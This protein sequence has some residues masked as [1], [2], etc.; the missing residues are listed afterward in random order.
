[1]SEKPTP[2]D[3]PSMAMALPEGVDFEEYV[4]ATY[5][6]EIS[7]NMG[8][9][10]K[11]AQA[12]AIEQSTGTWVCVPGETPEVRR[13]HVA[14]VLSVSQIPDYE[15]ERPGPKEE[16]YRTYILQIGFP[17][18]NVW[19][20]LGLLL[21]AIFGNI[22]MAGR[23]KMLDVRFP[24]KWLAEFKGPK[25]GIEGIRKLLKVPE[26]PLLNNMI[27]P[28]IYDSIKVGSELF[29]QAAVGGC[30]IIKDD[31]LLAN[32]AFNPISE[33][34]PAYMEMVDRAKSEKGEETLFTVNITDR[35]PNMLENA[36][37]AIE[38][39]AN[40]LMVNYP[41]VGLEIVRQICEDPSVKVPVLGHMDFAGAMYMAPQYGV[42]SHLIL[43]KFPRIAGCDILVHPAP[44]GKAS[45]L[46]DKFERVAHTCRMPLH[47]IKPMFPMPS[48]G[49]TVGMVDKCVESLG[50]DI[51]IGSGGGIHAHPD[52]AAA[53]AKAFRQAIDAVMQ[54]IKVKD[55]AKDHKELG[56]SLGTW[57]TGKIE[58]GKK[59]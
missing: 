43:A 6:G 23:L 54:G 18:E 12:I 38:L 56:V 3:Y 59:Y 8:I 57:G 32:Q 26:R 49:I 53:G 11:V 40:A 24:K 36:D 58:M 55:Y 42:S 48:G 51:V 27:K 52:G 50:P 39:G 35:M 22:S 2:D 25:F 33:R 28:C 19:N 46:N 21:T 29:Y 17:A 30:D 9:S 15:F 13:R 7:A 34:I 37:K 16:P 14:K 10:W 44:Y 1:M 45:V 31:E 47:N 4:V 5:F 20:T 41:V